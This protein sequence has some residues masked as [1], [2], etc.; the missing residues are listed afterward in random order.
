MPRFLHTYGLW[1]LAKPDQYR[2][3]CS[4]NLLRLRT[5]RSVSFV[6]LLVMSAGAADLLI[7]SAASQLG[8]KGMK[9]G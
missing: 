1:A 4:L 9:T 8:C 6:N 5:S 3:E 2:K 7:L